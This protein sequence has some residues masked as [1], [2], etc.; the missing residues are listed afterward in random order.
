MLFVQNYNNPSEVCIGHTWYL[1]VDMQLFVVAPI[2][3]FGL[4][5]KRK[6]TITLIAGL[7]GVAIGS[8]FY[9]SLSG[10]IRFSPV[11]DVMNNTLALKQEKICK[12]IKIPE[13]NF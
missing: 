12:S 7:I 4:F 3:V 10:G 6:L 13:L 9:T 8:T 11:K 1:S 5:K 2:L